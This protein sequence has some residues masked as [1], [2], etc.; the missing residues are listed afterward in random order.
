MQER[1]AHPRYQLIPPLLGRAF[2]DGIG[3]FEAQLLD[4]SVDGVRLLLQIGTPDE[5]ARFL[6]ATEKSITATFGRPEG[7]PWKFALLH[8]RMTTLDATGSAGARC[9]IAAR[10]VAVPNFT[11]ADLEGLV[12]KRLAARI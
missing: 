9:L 1:R 11:V 7:E 10:F 3:Q 5:L 6:A 8:T 2:V 4:V 12:A